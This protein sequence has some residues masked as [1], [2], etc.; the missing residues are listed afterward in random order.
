MGKLV[1]CHLV[2][3]GR[4]WPLFFNK[5]F[6]S[7]IMKGARYFIVLFC[8]KKRLKILYKCMTKNTVYEH[9][10]EFKSEKKPSFVK[11]QAGKRKREVKYEL[12]LVFPNNKWAKPTYVKDDLGRNVEVEMDDKRYRIKDIIPYWREE[13]IYDFDNKKRIRY[14]QMMDII[15]A[16]Q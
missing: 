3:I 16:C 14:S 15:L 12:G 11:L 10:H 4:V 6:I 5:I 9:W 13:L 2:L 7:H 1:C 8:N